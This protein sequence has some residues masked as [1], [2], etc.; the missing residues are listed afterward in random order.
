MTEYL[1]F[2]SVVTTPFSRRPDG[3]CAFV[4]APAQRRVVDALPA[5]LPASV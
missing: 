2:A 5:A 3:R 4:S 1:D